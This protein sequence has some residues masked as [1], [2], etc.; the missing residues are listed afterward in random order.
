MIMSL[1]APPTTR[2]RS[3]GDLRVGVKITVAV[4]LALVTASIA[5]VATLVQAGRIAAEGDRISSQNARAL[6]VL[7]ELRDTVRLH[8]IHVHETAIFKP[9]EEQLEASLTDLSADYEA[10]LALVKEYHTVAAAPALADQFASDFAAYV[11]E[12]DRQLVPAARRGDRDGVLAAINGDAADGPYEGAKAAVSQMIEAEQASAATRAA[13]LDAAYRSALVV[14]LALLG[15]ALLLGLGLALWVAR[16]ISRPLNAVATALDRVADGDL[17]ADVPRLDRRDEVGAMARALGRSLHSMR[18]SVA[19][20]L[21]HAGHLGAASAELTAVASQIEVG[22][23]TTAEQSHTA[24]TVAAD[25]SSSVNAVAAAAEQM[26]SAITEISR[27]AGAAVEVAQ[28]ALRTAVQT[29]S[30][31]SALGTA[32]VEIG[33]VVKV[34]NSIAEQTNL[35]ALNATIEAAR[36][37]E[38]GK[39]FA[40]VASEVKDLAQETAK[41]T[42]EITQKIQA[43]QVSSTEAA[44]ALTEIS[45]IVEQIIEHQ[46]T[47]A[48]AVEE[49]SATT[50]EISRGV[51]GAATGT[52]HI[53]RTVAQVN[54]AA[55][56]SNASAAA[57][58]EAAGNLASLADALSGSVARFRA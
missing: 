21:A 39:G 12:L 46:T 32:S 11:A 33:D 25:V 42:E 37:G 27:S 58:A 7:S 3:W 50:A 35:L 17:T 1:S 6:A 44:E 22:A 40:V 15:A 56:Q 51:A 57:A 2:R 4:L 34:I 36:A 10:L 31:V 5:T 26:H 13:D 20:V 49:Q 48:S 30:S 43:I 41:A 47:V 45:T 28:K 24:S 18:T 54:G 23:T 38:A 53:A 8:R 19:E 29:N 14:S 9:G 52:E 16:G 55:A